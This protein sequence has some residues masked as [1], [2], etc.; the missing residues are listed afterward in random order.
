[1]T[2]RRGSM[3]SRRDNDRRL[4]QALRVSAVRAACF[5]ECI[6]QGGIELMCEITTA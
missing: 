3:I 5:E 6:Q 1:M 4:L 2:G